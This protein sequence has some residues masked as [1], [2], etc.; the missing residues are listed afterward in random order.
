MTVLKSAASLTMQRARFETMTDDIL[1]DVRF[2][3]RDAVTDYVWTEAT[4][5]TRLIE[6]FAAMTDAERGHAKAVEI[7]DRVRSGFSARLQFD[8]DD[9][10]ELAIV[11]DLRKRTNEQT[12]N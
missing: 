4:T 1:I 12:I 7:I 2:C 11:V 5:H 8:V 3:A 10:P 6:L 9:Q